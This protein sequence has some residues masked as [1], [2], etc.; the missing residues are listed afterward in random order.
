[1]AQQPGIGRSESDFEL[2]YG[3]TRQR[4][5]GG[6]TDN[7]L[8]YW[9]GQEDRQ[10]CH[11]LVFCQEFASKDNRGNRTKSFPLI[12]WEIRLKEGRCLYAVLL[13]VPGWIDTVS[14]RNFR[15]S[16]TE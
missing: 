10:E 7:G 4:P 1:M 13:M 2:G 15:N 9:Q 5:E 8:R 3:F 12:S 6:L 14:R 11:C 16:E